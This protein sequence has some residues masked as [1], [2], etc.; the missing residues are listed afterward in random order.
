MES[1]DED[2]ERRQYS[3]KT[4]TREQRPCLKIGINEFEV[5][6]ISKNGIKFKKDKNMNIEGWVQ[7]TVIFKDSSFVAFDGIVVRNRD[8]EIGLHLI[9]PIDIDF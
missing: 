6:D 2:S 4:Y 9:D 5:I 7:G 3:R 1:Q 8:G